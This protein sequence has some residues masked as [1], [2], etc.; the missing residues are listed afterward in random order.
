VANVAPYLLSEAEA[1]AA[2]HLIAAAFSPAP[3]M[4]FLFPDAERRALLLPQFFVAMTRLA[5]RTGKAIGLGHPLQAV[6]LWLPPVGESPPEEVV[7][8]SGVP[9]FIALLDEA[10]TVRIEALATQLEAMVQRS[11]TGPHWYLAYAAVAPEHQ[12]QGLGTALVRDTLDQLAPTGLPCYLESADETNL[13]F[14]E[15]LD[16]RIV[17]ADL[18][19]DSQLRVWVLRRD[20]AEVPSQ[21]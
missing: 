2:G 11:L 13:R 4:A 12:G 9:A 14:Y 19:P 17:D 5:I 7:S 20:S 8:E 18:V 1:D 3:M 15:R 16:F 21:L 10:E 6:A